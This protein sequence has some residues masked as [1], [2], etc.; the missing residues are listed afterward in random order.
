M[1]PV[2][3]AMNA[4]MIPDSRNEQGTAYVIA[5][6][7]SVSVRAVI[8]RTFGCLTFDDYAKPFHFLS[9]YF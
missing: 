5:H 9:P 1:K 3:H 7:A 2:F 8:V 4:E 6:V